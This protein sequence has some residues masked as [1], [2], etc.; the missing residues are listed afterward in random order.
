MKKDDESNDSAY[1]TIVNDYLEKLIQYPYH[2]PKLSPIEIETYISL[3][4]CKK[5]LS[6]NG[7]QKLLAE[8][9]NV[10]SKNRFSSFGEQ[11]IDQFLSSLDKENDT[12]S[13][14]ESLAIV[15]VVA[16]L[17]MEYPIF[18]SNILDFIFLN[19]FDEYITKMKSKTRLPIIL[20]DTLMKSKILFN[21]KSK[22]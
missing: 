7:F 1:N 16:P 6:S 13:L 3:L 4:F 8:C 12:K 19:K 22:I 10:R 20:K 17:I 5:H 21:I 15:S 9:N 11:A 14:R 2:L 18:Y